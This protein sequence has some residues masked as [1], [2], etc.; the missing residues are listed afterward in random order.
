MIRSSKPSHRSGLDS[1]KKDHR[2]QTSEKTDREPLLTS[3]ARH[4]KG[5]RTSEN[6]RL[7]APESGRKSKSHEKRSNTP[8]QFKSSG[9]IRK[10]NGAINSVRSQQTYEK[11]TKE[12]PAKLATDRDGDRA[13]T[14]KPKE[15]GRKASSEAR[16][17]SV[18]GHLDNF[19]SVKELS[20]SRFQRQLKA[21]AFLTDF[22]NV[23]RLGLLDSIEQ[24]EAFLIESSS[25]SGTGKKTTRG[26][27][28]QNQ[29]RQQECKRSLI[30]RYTCLR[31]RTFYCISRGIC[32]QGTTE[33]QREKLIAWLEGFDASISDRI[34]TLTDEVEPSDSSDSSSYSSSDSSSEFTPKRRS[35]AE[36]RA[37][38]QAQNSLAVLNWAGLVPALQDVPVPASLESHL[39]EYWGTQGNPVG[40]G[41][42]VLKIGL[43]DQTLGRIRAHQ[44]TIA[45]PQHCLD[46]TDCITSLAII[47][48]AVQRCVTEACQ[49]GQ[50]S[51]PDR[52]KLVGWGFAAERQLS[53]KL[54]GY[55]RQLELTQNWMR[56]HD[57]DTLNSWLR[58][59]LDVRQVEMNED[60]EIL[61]ADIEP[62]ASRHPIFEGKPG[63]KG[64]PSF[65]NRMNTDMTPSPGVLLPLDRL[66]YPKKPLSAID[67][68]ERDLASN[69]TS[70]DIS[71]KL[72]I[73]DSLVDRY[74]WLKTQLED[75]CAQCRQL[76]PAL[77]ST[78]QEAI[79]IWKE[80]S[81]QRIEE[82]IKTCQT[83]QAKLM[84]KG[85]RSPRGH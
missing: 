58:L 4:S 67:S 41:Q 75:Y 16:S 55:W 72:R 74:Q 77:A 82:R 3:E 13:E 10:V 66:G 1:R 11:L 71:M 59:G 39:K 20:K 17:A 33:A 18:L 28:G 65:N 70:R 27:P 34:K 84:E 80:A 63:I 19:P 30:E 7:I 22:N 2:T 45:V 53:R 46:M 69:R 43:M 79:Q 54:H 32:R 37:A 68:L 50:L 9:V 42:V 49:D 73:L 62:D 47:R 8:Y 57:R 60:A 64:L 40:L 26:T 31:E 35:V 12:P 29:H 14:K 21:D 23:T 44:E 38:K 36:A 76:S 24:L 5:R 85:G 25:P 78:H 81:I 56:N 48:H 61:Q 83:Q 51:E 6:D 15:T 52:Q